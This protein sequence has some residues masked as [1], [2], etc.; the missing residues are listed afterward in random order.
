MSNVCP[1][2]GLWPSFALTFYIECIKHIIFLYNIIL[3][4]CN[5]LYIPHV[6]CP[7]CILLL[8]I[9]L[10]TNHITPYTIIPTSLVAKFSCASSGCAASMVL[11]DVHSDE[12][13]PSIIN[14][15][16]IVEKIL[17]VLV[18]SKQNFDESDRKCFKNWEF[19]QFFKDDHEIIVN[20][21]RR[22]TTRGGGNSIKMY[23]RGKITNQNTPI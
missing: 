19:D 8:V 2:V 21:T 16:C 14:L 3:L 13:P 5:T 1:F 17:T 22:S 20:K 6:Q 4:Y 7:K 11:S 10:C 9:I 23:P 18:D 15:N 12:M